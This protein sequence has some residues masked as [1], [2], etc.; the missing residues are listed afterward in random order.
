[1]AIWGL[2]T[3]IIGHQL[4]GVTHD[5]LMANF[6]RWVPPAAPTQAMTSHNLLVL[7]GESLP[8]PSS[9]EE[10]AVLVDGT[11]DLAPTLSPPNAVSGPTSNPEGTILKTY[12]LFIS[13][14][15]RYEDQ[16]DR[17]V[18]LLNARPYFAFRNYSVTPSD[19]VHSARNE[20][21]LR[22]AIRNH[23]SPCHVVLIMAGVYATCSKW[24]NIEIDLALEAFARAKPIIAVR[25]R[26]N[27]RISQRVR[28]SANRI[29]GWNTESIVKAIRDLA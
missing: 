13:H 20:S 7:A 6:S 22:R 11:P 16:Y 10:L 14:S 23:M 4:P 2:I 24:I 19:P 25:P 28:Q 21:Q 26:G 9:M 27:E 1:M 5:F 18:R 8:A 15:W 29:V 17:L 3:A 12:N